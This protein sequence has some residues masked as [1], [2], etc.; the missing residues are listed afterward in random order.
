VHI[1]IVYDVKRR[2][3]NNLEIIDITQA[4]PQELKNKDPIKAYRNYYVRDK[5]Y[6]FAWKGRNMPLWIKTGE[7]N[8]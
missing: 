7:D 3:K 4:I 2:E 1:V 8:V 5:G 6:L